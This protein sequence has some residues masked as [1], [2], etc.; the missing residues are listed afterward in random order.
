MKLPQLI[1]CITA[2]ADPSSEGFKTASQLVKVVDTSAYIRCAA[3]A[4]GDFDGRRGGQPAVNRVSG[5][6]G[7]HGAGPRTVFLQSAPAAW[8]ARNS[9]RVCRFSNMPSAAERFM[10][11]HTAYAKAPSAHLH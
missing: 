3:V 4:P 9:G 8:H 5:G 11:W 6:R 10:T 7:S 1:G 2:V